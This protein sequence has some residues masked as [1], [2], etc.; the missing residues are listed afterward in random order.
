MAIIS[1]GVF[2][3]VCLTMMYY[4]TVCLYI[5]ATVGDINYI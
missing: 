2:T 5:S 1:T 3:Q 4:W